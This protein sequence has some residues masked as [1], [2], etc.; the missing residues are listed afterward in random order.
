MEVSKRHFVD[1][2]EKDADGTFDYYYE[3]DV[4]EFSDGVKTFVGRSYTDTPEVAAFLGRD[5]Q[6]ITNG[7][8]VSPLFKEACEHLKKEGKT[9]IYFLDESNL[10]DGYSPVP[11]F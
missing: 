8:L 1:A 7:D 11:L 10:Q 6:F 5:G 2:G 3:Y 9:K 4:Y